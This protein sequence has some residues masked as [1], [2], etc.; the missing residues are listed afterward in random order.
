MTGDIEHTGRT[1]TAPTGND[2]KTNAR[3]TASHE[4]SYRARTE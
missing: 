1:A 2:K 3:V 4:D